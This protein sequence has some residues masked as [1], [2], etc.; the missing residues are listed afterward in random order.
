M[1]ESEQEGKRREGWRP[2]THHVRS[3]LLLCSQAGTLESPSY[4]WPAHTSQRY[5]SSSLRRRSPESE[6]SAVPS[7]HPL[8]LPSRLPPLPAL[9]P[10][11][12][13]LP[14]HPH[15]SHHPKLLPRNLDR[16][17]PSA[18]PSSTTVSPLATL[19]KATISMT[20]RSSLL[21]I[22]SSQY[23]Q[24][25]HQSSSTMLTYDLMVLLDLDSLPF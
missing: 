23:T 2:P 13:H 11:P 7:P 4:H 6:S 25:G 1:N 3:V 15:L 22:R 5:T 21:V 19:S 18:S 20:T 14:P 24:L 9:L 12:L 17:L 10:L 16:S 8:R